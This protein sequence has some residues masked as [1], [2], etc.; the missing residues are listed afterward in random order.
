[1]ISRSVPEG[2][3]DFPAAISLLESAQTLCRK[4]LQQGIS[5]SHGL[6]KFSGRF[7]EKALLSQRCRMYFCKN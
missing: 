6:L 2:G 4:I 3:A 5:D 1:M 7:L